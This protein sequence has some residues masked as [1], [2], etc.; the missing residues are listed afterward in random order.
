M[1]ALP[2]VTKSFGDGAIEVHTVKFHCLA[3]A[4][5]QIALGKLLDKPVQALTP[6]F[7]GGDFGPPEIVEALASLEWSTLKPLLLKLFATTYAIVD[8]KRYQLQS[9]QGIVAAF[10]DDAMVMFEVAGFVI[11]ENFTSFF[12]KLGA[13]LQGLRGVPQPAAASGSTSS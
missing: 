10:G 13:R 6:L 11:M 8:G 2:T 4:E 12:A 3:N 7:N 5:M 9:E 1:S